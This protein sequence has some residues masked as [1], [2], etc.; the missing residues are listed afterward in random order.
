M[1]PALWQT[2]YNFDYILVLDVNVQ[3]PGC[4][5]VHPDI[6]IESVL[7]NYWTNKTL[8]NE[9]VAG[10]Y[11]LLMDPSLSMVF[12]YYHSSMPSILP[13]Y[14]ALIIFNWYVT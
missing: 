3:V 2:I 6:H 11:E 4:Q 13:A 14:L 9:N 1:G 5:S 8:L 12:S 7:A 10:G